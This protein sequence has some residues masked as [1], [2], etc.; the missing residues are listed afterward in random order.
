MLVALLCASAFQV[1]APAVPATEPRALERVVVIG[2]SLSAGFGAEQTLAQVFAAALKPGHAEPVD[3]GDALFFTSPLSFGARMVEAALDE[4]PS[5]VL[6]VDFLFW[7]GYGSTDAE[8]GAMDSE[9]ER[10]ALLEHGLAFL[11]RLECPLVVGD[12][13]DMSEAVGRMISPAQMP[14]KATLPRLSQRVR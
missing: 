1:E 5:L 12:F 7:F 3:Y 10:L 9:D 13:P 2:A 11:A 14:E 4:E 6:A 8:G